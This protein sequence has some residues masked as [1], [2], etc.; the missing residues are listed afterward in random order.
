[1]QDGYIFR[2]MIL[3]IDYLYLFW[4]IFWENILIRDFIYVGNFDSF[5]YFLDSK[6]VV[7]VNFITSF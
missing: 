4:N 1:M 3:K 7:S 5:V 2:L 6:K